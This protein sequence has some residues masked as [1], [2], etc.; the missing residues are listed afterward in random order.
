MISSMTQILCFK[1]F[2]NVK[3]LIKFLLCPQF[4]IHEPSDGRLK[5]LRARSTLSLVIQFLT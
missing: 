3:R 4:L 2:N 1:E 5:R